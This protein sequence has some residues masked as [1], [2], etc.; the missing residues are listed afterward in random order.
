MSTLCHSD[1]PFTNTCI[2]SFFSLTFIV[3]TI[4]TETDI[5]E[6]IIYDYSS[7]VLIRVTESL[8]SRLLP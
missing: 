4:T 2:F 7:T 5:V 1:N 8:E 6:D 3:T